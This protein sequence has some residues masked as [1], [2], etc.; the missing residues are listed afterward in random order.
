MTCA[1]STTNLCKSFGNHQV[2]TDVNMEVPE[3]SIYGFVG[4][5]GAGKTT[6]IRIL[7][8]LAA[9]TKG[10]ANVLGTI[11]G[12]LPPTPISGVS[13]LPDVPHIS[14]W[15]GARDALIFL[16]RLANV[17]P[18][19]A[20]DRA[21]DLL[22]LVGLGRAPGK[23]GNFSRGMKQRLGIAAALVT[24]P[25]LLVLDEPTSAL[26]PL[27]RADVLAV[28]K[29]L[30]GHATVI[31]STHILKDVQN[32]STHLGILRRGRLIAQGSLQELLEAGSQPYERLM[33]TTRR[34]L[35]AA[36]RQGIY[37]IDPGAQIERQSRD[38]EELFATLNA[39]QDRGKAHE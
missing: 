27:G 25:R 16:A 13:Y 11:R 14:P 31:F 39:T 21:H 15:L 37:S 10:S 18:D 17:P 36:M 9:A 3:G 2:I 34:D 32:V 19:C 22:D 4:A 12:S 20:S 24:A 1:V 8:G 29:Q 7:L 5:N 6:T 26:D 38:L 28:I 30:A 23:I 35:S 33:I